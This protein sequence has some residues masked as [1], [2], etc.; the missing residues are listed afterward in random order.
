MLTT[1]SL[2]KLIRFLADTTPIK[3]K[4]LRTAHALVR[5]S[6]GTRTITLSTSSPARH[7]LSLLIH[8]LCHVALDSTLGAFGAFEEPIIDLVLVPSLTRYVLASP[9]RRAWWSRRIGAALD[10]S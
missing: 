6:N 4:P 8:E 5:F 9:A 10:E 1:A 2:H 3:F 7:R